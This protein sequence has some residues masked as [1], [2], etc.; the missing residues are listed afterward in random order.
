LIVQ[1]SHVYDGKSSNSTIMDIVNYEIGDE[2]SVTANFS[3]ENL[4]YTKVKVLGILEMSPIEDP[5][6][7]NEGDYYDN[8]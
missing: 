8:N 2:I 4:D 5:Y 1:T 3:E 6:N 7:L